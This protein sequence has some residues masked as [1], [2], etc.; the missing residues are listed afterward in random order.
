MNNESAQTLTRKAPAFDNEWYAVSLTSEVGRKK[1]F[2]VRL[3]GRDIALWRTRAGKLCAIDARCPHM[4]ASLAVGKVADDR[5]ECP[6]HGFQ[7]DGTGRCVKTPLRK[8]DAL[9]PR[10]LCNR[11]YA[12]AEKLGWIFLFWGEAENAPTEIPFFDEDIHEPLAHM[13]SVREWPVSF[14]RFIENTV[15]VAHLGTVHRGTLSYTIPD[16]IDVNAE[17]S[18]NIISMVPPSTTDLPVASRIAY[19]NMAILHL[20]PKFLTVFVAVPVDEDHSRIY[21]RSSQAVIR[22]P[23]I[24]WLFS[25]IKHWADMAALWQDKKALFSVRPVRIEDAGREVLMEFEP[26]IVA[27]RKMR[28]Q[29][30]AE[31]S[32]Q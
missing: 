16:V 26:Q 22:W 30:M 21:V 24:G 19:P 11:H 3:Y 10:T 6:Y 9:I 14:T 4:G 15:D 2:G 20:H 7:Y 18:G 1:P 28:K 23:L 31:L 25:K 17:V 32:Q 29:R 27:Y 5:V 8:P 12:V 13:Y